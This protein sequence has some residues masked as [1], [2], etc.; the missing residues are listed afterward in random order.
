M[1]TSPIKIAGLG[2]NWDERYAMLYKEKLC[3]VGFHAKT[4]KIE[5]GFYVAY[6]YRSF[7]FEEI[8][9]TLNEILGEE[10]DER[11]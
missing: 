10:N 6:S 4:L 8:Q 11:K 3:E 9:V 7:T 1:K 2:C 5:D